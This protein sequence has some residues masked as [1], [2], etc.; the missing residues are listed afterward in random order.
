MA[1]TAASGFRFYRTISGAAK[2][3]PLP[4][5]IANS[6]T[7]RV[8]DTVRLNTAGFLVAS[9]DTGVLLG[10]LDGFA[11]KDGINPF[12]LGFP[13]ASGATLTGDDTLATASDNQTATDDYIEALVIVDPSGNV[14]WL[15]DASADLAQTNVLQ[16]FDTTGSGRQID[17]ASAL[18]TNGQFQLILWDPKGASNVPANPTAAD[19]SFGAFRI[20][21]NQFSAGIDSATAKNAA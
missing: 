15:N 21:E 3:S 1:Q 2:A 9:G 13:T 12:S 17:Q 19:A 16:F 20:N 10:V 4:F 8:G 14:L 7:L 11:N 18:D 5:R 6:T